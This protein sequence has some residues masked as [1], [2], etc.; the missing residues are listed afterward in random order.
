VVRVGRKLW[1][2]EDKAPP[3]NRHELHFG[4]NGSRSLDLRNLRWFDHEEKKGG[5]YYQLFEMA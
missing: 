5:G 3:S 1:G 2:N 4:T